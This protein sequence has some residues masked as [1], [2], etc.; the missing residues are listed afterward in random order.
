MV[1]WVAFAFMTAAAIVAVCWP[2]L[3]G[4]RKI[5]GGSDL[6]VYKD[7]LQEIDRDRANG[8]IGESEAEA[9]RLEVSRRLLAAANA[10]TMKI[11]PAET[12]SRVV[13]RR[14]TAIVMAAVVLSLGAP[15]LY[16]AL[17]SPNIP[18]EPVFARVKTPEGQQSI[19]GLVSQV[20]ARLAR[21]PNDG[22]GWEVIAP[23]YL[24]L[25]RFDD[26]VQ[27]RKK[28]LQLNGESATRQA[29]LGE[30]EAAAAD[31]IVTADARAAFERA[32]TLDPHE[33]KA[34][35]FLGLAAEQDGRAQ[36]AASIWR[37]LLADA[38]SGAPWASFVREALA[39]VT[40]APPT[41]AGPSASDVA[42]A[43]NMS[44]QARR[45]MI[46]GMVARLADRLRDNGAD[47]DGWLRLVR[48]YTV[49]GDRDK[50]KSAA[51]DARRALAD[52]PED[53]R[54]IDDLVKTLGLSG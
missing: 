51:A 10:S 25:G 20:E 44:E 16:V 12:G 1:L 11:A 4:P 36:D 13:K 41:E 6:L 54:R 43:A 49:L 45:D 33:S 23:V 35:Y 28:S 46:S 40:G 52:H 47:I 48:A 18:A 24:R 21:N 14:R 50:A 3:R 53:L 30:A 31:G 42:A 38:P 27:A 32:V 26:A 15:G 19:T 9:A 5:A 8:L 2:L 39:R 34:R 17:G 37:S 7:Q 22:M 29:D